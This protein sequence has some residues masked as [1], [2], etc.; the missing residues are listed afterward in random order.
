VKEPVTKH[1]GTSQKLLYMSK[2]I[3]SFERIEEEHSSCKLLMP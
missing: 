3:S 2:L 1:Q